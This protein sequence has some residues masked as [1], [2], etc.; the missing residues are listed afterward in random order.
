[1]KSTGA[2]RFMDTSKLLSER[3]SFLKMGAFVSAA[4]L[5]DMLTPNPAV[6]AVRG[7]DLDVATEQVTQFNLHIPQTQLDALRSRLKNTIWPTKETVDDWSQGVPL[8]KM[9]DLV[10]Y[11]QNRY[12]WRRFETRLNGFGQYR[13]KIDGLGIHFLHIRSKHENALPMVMTHGW[14]GSVVEFVKLEQIPADVGHRLYP[15]WRK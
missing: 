4:A 11:W 13:T 6:A 9:R 2:K 3:R 7:V 15:A 5:A 10:D 1:M 8:A 14:P 12:D